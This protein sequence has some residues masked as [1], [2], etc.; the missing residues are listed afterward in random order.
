MRPEHIELLDNRAFRRTRSTS[1]RGQLQKKMAPVIAV[2]GLLV[3]GVAVFYSVRSSG[4]TDHYYDDVRLKCTACGHEFTMSAGN[5]ARVRGAAGNPRARMPCP[6]C[7]KD[8]GD[9]MTRC[10]KCGAW[11]LGNPADAAA[12]M[13]CSHCGYNPDA[14]GS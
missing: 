1:A 6:K 13:K 2:L 7:K 11:F 14:G 10:E 12:G 4:Q 9:E 5:M 8:A 3:A